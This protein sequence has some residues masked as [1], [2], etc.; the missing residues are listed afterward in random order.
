MY[1]VASGLSMALLPTHFIVL[2]FISTVF[3]FL[4]RYFQG[5]LE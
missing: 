5:E 3:H 1:V 4:R 2:A